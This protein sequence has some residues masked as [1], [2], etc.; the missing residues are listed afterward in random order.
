MSGGRRTADK[1]GGGQNWKKSELL[2][3]CF[4]KIRSSVSFVEL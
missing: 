3:I 1:G 4:L 2:L